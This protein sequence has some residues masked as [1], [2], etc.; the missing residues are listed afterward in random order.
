MTV[1]GIWN[2]TIATPIGR[3]HATLELSHL[4]DALHGIAKGQ[5]EDVPLR[6]ILAQGN[7]LTW[8]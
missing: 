6:D 7:R 1:D 8:A 4:G 3:Q 2:L 5:S